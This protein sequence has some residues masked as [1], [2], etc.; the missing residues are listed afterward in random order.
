MSEDVLIGLASIVVLGVSA[1]WLASR[2][3]IPSILL[4]LTFGFLAG[5]VTHL[6]DPNV[7]LD[8][9]LLFPLV[10]ISVALILYEGG[11]T[12]KL[13]EL[14]RIGGVVRNLISIGALVTWVISGVSAHFLFGL[15]PGVATLL[16]AVLVV[17]GPTVI[18]PLLRHIRP[19]GPVEPALK[20]EG[21]IIDPIGAVLAVLVYEV[22]TIT[23]DQ[24][25]TTHVIWGLTKTILLGGGLGLIAAM[26]L[27]F[28]LHRYWIPDFLQNAVSLM[29]VVT[30]FTL[31]NHG[32]RESG[33]LAVTVMGITL[34]NQKLANVRHIVEFKENLRV[35]LLSALF[36]VLAARLE[37]RDVTAVLLPGI[38]FV[39]I[40]V[41]VARPLAVYFSTI[42][43][44][45]SVKER[46]FLAWMA[47]R[48][49]VAA[50]VASLFALY[51]E[52]QSGFEEARLLVPITF[53]VI[54]GTVAIYG[55]T[56][57]LVA[58]WLG[59]ADPNPQGVLLT[60]AHGW[61]RS[62]AATLQSKGFAV[63]LVDSNR[64]NIAAARMEGLTTYSGSVLA[65]YAVD[66]MSLGGI[67]RLLAVTP[68]DWVNVLAV[69]RF[70]RHFGHA[71]CYQLAPHDEPH[72]QQHRHK[73]MH[74]RWL[75][76]E[77]QTFTTLTRRF[78]DGARFKATPL[79]E[80]FDYD[81]FCEL[82]GDTAIPLMVITN[83]GRL[84][85]L[86][87][88]EQPKPVPGQ[89]LISL[90]IEGPGDK[91]KEPGGKDEQ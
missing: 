69:Q 77:K 24:S 22:I 17:T 48:G 54:I 38:L 1:Q 2:I 61:A 57:P 36:I 53:L 28:L 72:G 56:S 64:A 68:N 67:G 88:D 18:G 42:G 62:L 3:R 50:A 7:L 6:L 52:K 78:A 90:A 87:A 91:Q 27:T 37:L 10:S 35:L 26:L 86:T 4:L 30:V 60:G 89:T 15:S 29:L 19:T 76:G 31:A 33:L 21:I 75:F 47:P 5:P 16:G 59:V 58:R 81:A 70:T 74:G 55:L 11:L 12:L 79:T 8:K 71:S 9:K 65:E 49:I 46:L 83:N 40:L 82:Y 51:L 80:S 32:Q 44:K 63:L 39:L 34:A 84:R 41:L 85:I 43:A 20:W 66:E 73:H 45:L 23:G 25:A 14:P 13:S